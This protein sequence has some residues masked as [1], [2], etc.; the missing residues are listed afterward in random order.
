MNFGR[1]INARPPTSRQ[2]HDGNAAY[3]ER[4]NSAQP[5]TL[6]RR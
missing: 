1:A 2:A 5:T 3:L 4:D 6:R